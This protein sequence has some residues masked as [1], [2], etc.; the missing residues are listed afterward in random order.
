MEKVINTAVNMAIDEGWQQFVK[1][2]SY[3]KYINVNSLKVGR[4]NHK[5]S[6]VR[7][8]I[9]DSRRDQLKSK[10]LT[11]TYILQG[12]R[13]DFNQFQ[14]HPTCRLC[15]AE[16]ETRQ[17]FISECLYLNK[18]RAA[19]SEKLLKNPVFQSAYIDKSLIKTLSF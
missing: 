16:R 12:H 1:R 9:Y 15:I 17:H 18:E 14:V 3:L 19:Y 4:T 5:R 2:K 13:E 10:L 8:S 11:G 6:T 7:N